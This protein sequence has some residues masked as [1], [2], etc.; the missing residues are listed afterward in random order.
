MEYS[1]MY[2]YVFIRRVIEMK[3]LFE[4]EQIGLEFFECEMGP[5]N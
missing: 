4:M 2:V 3:L 5:T 1:R